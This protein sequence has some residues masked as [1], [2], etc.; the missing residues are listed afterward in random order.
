MFHVQR[1]DHARKRLARS[2]HHGGRDPALAVAL[3]RRTQ[4]RVELGVQLESLERT[5][6]NLARRTSRQL[7]E[8]VFGNRLEGPRGREHFFGLEH[9]RGRSAMH[10]QNWALRRPREQL[11]TAISLGILWSTHREKP[12]QSDFRPGRVR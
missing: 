4:A 9:P 8:T 12:A 7:W 11:H 3:N 5:D 10:D 1:V 2:V 6:N